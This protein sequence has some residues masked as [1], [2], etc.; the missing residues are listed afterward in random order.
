NECPTC[1]YS[2]SH[3]YLDE[4]NNQQSNECNKQKQKCQALLS[5]FYE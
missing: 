1:H 2:I 4:I 3:F 5:N